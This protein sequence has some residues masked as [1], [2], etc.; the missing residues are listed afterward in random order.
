VRDELL[1]LQSAVAGRYSIEREIGRGGMGRVY[2]ARDV[3]LDRP[4]AMKVLPPEHA[5]HGEV[6]DRFL[7]EARIAARLSH[8]NIVP[9]FAVEEAGDYVFF[10]MAYV[11]GETLRQRVAVRGPLPVSIGARILR[12]VAWALAYAHSQGVVHRDVKPENI[13][14][15]AGTDRALVTDFGIAQ[16]RTARPATGEGEVL[17]TPEF[18][19]PEQASGQDVDHRSDLYSFGVVAFYVFAGRVPFNARTAPAVLALHIGRPAPRLGTVAP[20]VPRRIAALVDQ[21]LLKQ[22]ADRVQRSEEVLDVLASTLEQRKE[23]PPAVRI[24]LAERK[25]AE[26]QSTVTLAFAPWLLMMLAGLLFSGKPL[27][28]LAGVGVAGTVIGWPLSRTVLGARRLIKAGHGQDDVVQGLAQ[29][30]ER[31]R[32]ELIYLY[33][34]DHEASARRRWRDALMCLGFALAMLAGVFLQP[35]GHGLLIGGALVFALVGGAL[36]HQANRRRDQ[37]GKHRLRLWRGPMGK[38]LFGVS[39][40]GLEVQT[41][42]PALTQRPTEVAVG[43]VVRGLFEALPKPMRANLGDLPQVVRSLEADAKRMRESIRE[44]DGLLGE[45]S[46]RPSQSQGDGA[47]VLQL[48]HESRAQAASRLAQTVAA[49]EKLRIDLLRLRAGNISITGVTENLGKARELSADVRLLLQGLAEV[50]KT[51]SKR[52]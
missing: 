17:G 12:D 33:G 28:M 4:V 37:K 21:C 5:S 27:L 10:V 51:L 8:P 19:S 23:I 50:E 6:R 32:E 25:A 48:L 13:L 24:F 41:V 34:K 3:A 22:P 31:R 45:A 15:E 52:E 26:T 39:G 49:L 43:T 9:I 42:A 14:L 29:E 40:W 2:L 7:L 30:L 46:G 47:R 18:M 35:G 44:L 16:V 1:A 38:W 11:E 20:G 36:G